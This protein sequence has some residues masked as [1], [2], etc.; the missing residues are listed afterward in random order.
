MLGF[1]ED[2]ALDR[3]FLG[4]SRSL[5]G[6]AWRA[7]LDPRGEAIAT[8]IAQRGIASE[9]LARV[10]AARGIGSTARPPIFRRR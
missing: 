1:A 9:A 10:L 5:T 4:V 3:H 2:R 7:R 8:A 6:R